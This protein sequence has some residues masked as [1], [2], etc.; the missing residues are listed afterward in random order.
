MVA[1]HRRRCRSRSRPQ[2]ARPWAAE[3]SRPARRSKKVHSFSRERA[4]IRQDRPP[5]H[6]LTFPLFARE[7]TLSLPFLLVRWNTKEQWHDASLF[8]LVTTAFYDLL[9]YRPIYHDIERL[10]DEREPWD[11]RG[12]GQGLRSRS[13]NQRD[14][15]VPSRDTI[16]TRN[17][18]CVGSLA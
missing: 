17:H 18:R 4:G 9:A 14:R 15:L 5:P 6:R 3:T 7:L 8:P 13:H 1:K 12:R 11:K 16:A 10:P 2:L